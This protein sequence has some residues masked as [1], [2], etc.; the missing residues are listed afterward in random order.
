MV[1]RWG[2]WVCVC[3]TTRVCLKGLN[4]GGVWG[5]GRGV[6]TRE[7]GDWTRE[8]L[9]RCSGGFSLP[10][11]LTAMMSSALTMAL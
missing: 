10:S 3:L 11:A 6:E 8:Q 1:V 9:P 2:S 4:E 7:E 5:L